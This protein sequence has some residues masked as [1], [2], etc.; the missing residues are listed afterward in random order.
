[1]TARDDKRERF[2]RV[3]GELMP[4]INQAIGRITSGEAAMRIPV[5]KTD[6]DIVLGECSN[7][8]AYARDHLACAPS[9]AL[10]FTTDPLEGDLPMEHPNRCKLRD[11]LLYA[12]DQT[13]AWR[14]RKRESHDGPCSS[15]NDC[16]V[17]GAGRT[18]CGMLPGHE[19]PHAWA[20]EVR[21]PA[22]S[23]PSTTPR[24]GATP[25]E[26]AHFMAGLFS[27]CHELEFNGQTLEKM[28]DVEGYLRDQAA[29]SATRRSGDITKIDDDETADNEGVDRLAAAMKA[30]LKAKRLEGRGGWHNECTIERLRSM[31][32]DHIGKGDVLDVAN[33]VMMIW[34]RENPNN[35]PD[36]GKATNG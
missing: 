34:N 21:V 9:H 25:A 13:P 14:C 24:S 15:H 27:K 16:G 26:L 8:L 23:A 6:P 12:H 33:F 17:M 19:G 35:S 36:G 28:L 20:T 32:L 3:V 10:R 2:L 4:R 29:L 31:Y 5:D 1:M 22:A 7:A 11:G 18:V 30:K